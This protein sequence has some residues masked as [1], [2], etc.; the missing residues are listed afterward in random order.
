MSSSY[1]PTLASW[2]AGTTDV[3]HQA[4]Q[5]KIDFCM[6]F[7]Y[8]GTLINLLINYNSFS[9]YSFRFSVDPIMLPLNKDGFPIHMPFMPF[10]GLATMARSSNAMLN[11]SGASH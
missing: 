3:H 9:I 7:L 5:S 4:Q 1:T 6:L 2:V 10:S 8:P 11:R